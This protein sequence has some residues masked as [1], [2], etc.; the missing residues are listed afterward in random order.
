MKSSKGFTLPEVL[1][2]LGVFL[3]ILTVIGTLLSFGV[4]QSLRQ[5]QRSESMRQ[6]MIQATVLG[7]QLRTTAQSSLTLYRPASQK[8]LHLAFAVPQDEQGRILR[9]GQQLLV[10]QSYRIWYRKAGSSHL[11]VSQIP[12]SMPSSTPPQP[13]SPSEIAAAIVARPGKKVLEQVDSF[14][15]LS[16][17]S[18]S[19]LTSP[20]P[21]FR[22]RI[23]LSTDQLSYTQAVRFLR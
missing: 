8:D 11:L 7:D 22:L 14:E 6:L 2:T 17:H 3:L 23:G 9:D 5:N 19:P 1:V 10:Y 15:A 20:Q 16:L 4:R 12:I 18:D 13:L 21:G